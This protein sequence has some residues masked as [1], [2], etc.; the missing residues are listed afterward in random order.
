MFF[1]LFVN[2]DRPYLIICDVNFIQHCVL[3]SLW[4]PSAPR[5]PSRTSQTQGSGVRGEPS[6]PPTATDQGIQI[7]IVM[8]INVFTFNCC[9]VIV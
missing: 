1:F 3:G 7:S 9:L 6:G 2:I 4:L 5:A 8:I